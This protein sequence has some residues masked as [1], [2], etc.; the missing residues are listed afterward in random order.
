MDSAKSLRAAFL[1]AVAITTLGV[2]SAGFWSGARAQAPPGAAPATST[3]V[4]EIPQAQAFVAVVVFD[5]RPGDGKRA[6]LVYVCDG[7]GRVNEWF[8]TP[9]S[10]AGATVEL[11]S[12]DGAR[13][14]AELGPQA[15]AGTFTPRGG[16]PMRFEARPAI[17][18]AGLYSVAASAGRLQGISAAGSQLQATAPSRPEKD[19]Y[20]IAGTVTPRHGGPLQLNASLLTPSRLDEPAAWIVLADSRVRGQKR[21][22][23]SGQ[24]AGGNCSLWQLIKSSVFGVHC[25]FL[26]T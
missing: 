5:L 18:A 8:A 13:I 22:V 6:T 10:L 3:F 7:T 20:R 2:L 15:V 19:G 11:Q 23:S 25:Q 12:A 16:Q 4:G 9:T 17:G 21:E 24:A 26:S 14:H 1:T